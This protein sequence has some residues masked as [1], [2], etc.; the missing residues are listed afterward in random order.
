MAEVIGLKADARVTTIFSRAK[1]PFGP[2]A[3]IRVGGIEI[4]L[5]SIRAQPYAPDAFT[6]VGIDPLKKRI[7]TLKSSQHFNKLFAPIATNVFYCTTPAAREHVKPEMYRYLPRPVWPHDD[8][9][10]DGE[11]VRPVARTAAQ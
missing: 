6:Q 4:V 10:F 1:L 3:G 9:E 7:I 2:A 11:T 5:N 8:I